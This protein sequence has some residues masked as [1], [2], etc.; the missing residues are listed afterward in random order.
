MID[1]EM[2]TWLDSMTIE[3][4]LRLNTVGMELICNDGHLVA[5][6]SNMLDLEQIKVMR[7]GVR[8]K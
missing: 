8:R 5:I 2:Q 4:A 3:D 6:E 7:K 1:R